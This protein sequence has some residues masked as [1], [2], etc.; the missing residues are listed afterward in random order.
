ME[1]GSLSTN[2]IS[3]EFVW[4][5]S[6]DTVTAA[7]EFSQCLAGSSNGDEVSERGRVTDMQSWFKKYINS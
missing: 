2:Y 7:G 5:S 1:V 6:V 4:C 3:T